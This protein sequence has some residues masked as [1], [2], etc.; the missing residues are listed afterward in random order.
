MTKYTR[1][2]FVEKPGGSNWPP[3][4]RIAVLLRTR[5]IIEQNHGRNGL[6][7]SKLNLLTFQ[8]KKNSNM[9]RHKSPKV[10]IA[11]IH[12]RKLFFLFNPV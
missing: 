12:G 7:S 8:Q 9:G 4:Y 1:R 11:R 3:V 5:Q 2:I 6:K 10:K